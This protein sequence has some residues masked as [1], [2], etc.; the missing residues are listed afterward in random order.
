MGIVR[1]VSMNKPDPVDFPRLLSTGCRAGWEALEGRIAAGIARHRSG[2]L[3]VRVVDR[4][5]RAIPGAQ[6][7]MDLVRHR[8]LFGAHLFLV[9]HFQDPG[10]AERWAGLFGADRRRHPGALFNAGTVALYWRDL[11]PEPGRLRYTAASEHIHRR[12]P[13]DVAVDF[14]TE[15]GLDLNGH[16][17][18]WDHPGNSLPDWLPADQTMH[19]ARLATRIQDLGRRYGSRIR[20]WDVVNEAAIRM[21]RR[22]PDS[23]GR[24]DSPM[25]VDYEHLAFRSAQASMPPEAMLMINEVTPLLRDRG[26]A[27]VYRSLIRDLLARGARIGAIG[28]QCHQWIN[29]VGGEMDFNPLQVWDELDRCAEFGL[30]LHIS[31]ITV[32]QFGDDE[33]SQQVQAAV[34]RRLYRLC[35]AHPAVHAITWW[36]A[37]DGTAWGPE[38][39]RNSGLLDADCRPKPA[40]AALDGLINGEWAP[41]PSANTDGAGSCVLRGTCGRTLVTVATGD[42][43]GSLEV[44]LHAEGGLAVVTVG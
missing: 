44:E 33:A 12:P 40:H 39:K 29:A 19:A 27:D 3:E 37:V 24:H 9:D 2:D 10:R 15:R 22:V 1:M 6:V 34:A 36:N 8:V 5:G 41:T 31:E 42:R 28:I 38:N 20:R 26:L 35:Y 13:A 18:A 4:D 30:P 7:R 25:P 32:A 16:C 11:E 17:L 14:G 23:V 21:T 43:S